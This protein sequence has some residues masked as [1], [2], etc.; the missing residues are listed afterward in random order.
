MDSYRKILAAVDLG[1]DTERVLAY[2]LWFARTAE[3]DYGLHLLHVMDYTFTPPA[4][5]MPYM[6]K[7]KADADTA[8][9]TWQ[10]RL[11]AA[12]VKS[13]HTV[14]VGRLV[15][16][17][18]ASIKELSTGVLVLGHQ[19]HLVRPS[20]SERLVRSLEV[21]VLVV[22]GQKAKGAA[23][24]AVAVRKIVCAVDFS[25]N[26]R[27]A[28]DFGRSLADKLSAELV[29]AHVVPELSPDKN[30]TA[31]KNMSQ[32]EREEYTRHLLQGA[33]EN[34]CSF[35][36]GC[37]G[38]Q[39]VVRGGAPYKTINEIAVE[40]D[41]DLIVMGARGLSY[42]KGIVLGSVSESVLKSSPCPVMVIH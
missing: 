34:I 7:E 17:F 5:L 26:S 2:A 35:L 9:R 16:T 15:E 12:G 11:S 31:L 19:S 29:M 4:Y 39:S 21:P 1:P 42:I 25:D 14:A 41:A 23:L 30:P 27:R 3:S 32:T 20:S 10:E 22:R 36:H 33:E 8:L 40:K 38:M 37:G 13:A 28:M 24:G 18:G 6:E